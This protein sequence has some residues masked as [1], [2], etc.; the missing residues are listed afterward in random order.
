VEAT[1][2][3]SP[4]GQTNSENL[5]H[6]PPSGTKKGG[7]SIA[8]ISQGRHPEAVAKQEVEVPAD[9]RR[10]RDEMSQQP[11]RSDERGPAE[12][13]DRIWDKFKALIE[14]DKAE[15][16]SLRVVASPLLESGLAEGGEVK[17]PTTGLEDCNLMGEN[18]R[19]QRRGGWMSA[20]SCRL[21]TRRELRH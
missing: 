10:R 17:T 6:L 19:G 14:R 12:I 2:R 16:T 18:Q 4:I 3:S 15:F 13:P 21:R 1:W 5:C 9:R 11:A 7:G 8:T 20:T